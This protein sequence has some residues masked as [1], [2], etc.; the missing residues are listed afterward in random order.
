MDALELAKVVQE[1]IQEDV[2]VRGEPTG[3]WDD[4]VLHCEDEEG[5][6]FTLSVNLVEVTEERELDLNEDV[7]ETEEDLHG[8]A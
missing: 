2:L 4:A 6:A 1:A 7:E 3:E 5:N 8:M